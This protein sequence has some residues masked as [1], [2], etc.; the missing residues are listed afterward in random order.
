[1]ENSSRMSHSNSENKFNLK[2]R[3]KTVADPEEIIQVIEK[4]K[5]AEER[6]R[7]W[8]KKTLDVR[9]IRRKAEE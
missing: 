7:N 4:R 1:M 8:K 5:V 3:I 2:Q 6:L 9:N